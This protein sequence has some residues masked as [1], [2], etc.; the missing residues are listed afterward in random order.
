M[1]CFVS[2]AVSAS[3]AR[4]ASQLRPEPCEVDRLRQRGA[5]PGDTDYK[6]DLV[7]TGNIL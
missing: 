5:I 2:K 7:S 3:A 1:A 4:L 6:S